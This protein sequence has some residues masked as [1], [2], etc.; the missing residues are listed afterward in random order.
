MSQKVE[1][2]AILSDILRE[3]VQTSSL[4]VHSLRDQLGKKWDDISIGFV[5]IEEWR[6]MEK[7]KDFDAKY[8]A[9]T[10]RIVGQALADEMI[11][12]LPETRIRNNDRSYS[13]SWWSGRASYHAP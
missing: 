2:V 3:S 4:E 8:N 9:Q 13:E 12:T 7:D 11:D 1:D 10:V 6:L 5:D